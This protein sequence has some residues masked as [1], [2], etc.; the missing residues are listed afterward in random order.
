MSVDNRLSVDRER[1]NEPH[2]CR[3]SKRKRVRISKPFPRKPPDRANP[4]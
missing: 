4:V 2:R 3:E 1:R